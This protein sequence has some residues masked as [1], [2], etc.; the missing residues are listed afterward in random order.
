MVNNDAILKAIDDLNSQDAPNVRS[1]TKQYNVHR[2]T[3]QRRYNGQIISYD[4]AH[5]RSLKLLTNAQES[6]LIEYINKLSTRG[7]HPTPQMLENLVVE[8]VGKPIGGR[9]IDRFCKRHVGQLTS[10]YLRSIDQAKHI[11]DNSKHFQHYFDLVSI[12]IG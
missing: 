9:W 11:A 8:L 10:I 4:E 2:S 1:T 6:V 12:P 5:S 3:L 7:L